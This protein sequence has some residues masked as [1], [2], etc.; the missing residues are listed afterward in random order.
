MDRVHVIAATGRTGNAL[1]RALLA[2]GVQV[3]P[4]VRD[5]AKFAALGLPASARVADLDDA[6]ALTTALRDATLIASTA[7]ARHAGAIIAAAPPAARLVMLGS[8]RRYSRWPDAH[9]SGVLAG[10]AALLN[11]G[12][13]GIMLHPT[14]IYGA[15]GENNVQRLARLLRRLPV[16]PLPGGGRNLVQPMHQDDVTACILAALDVPWTGPRSMVIAGPAP[17]TYADFIR[18]I[19]R[20]AGLAEPR[21]MPVPAGLLMALTPLT[22]LP[23]LPRVRTG[24]IRR[25]LED[26][27]FSVAEMKE[28]LGVMPVAFADGLARGFA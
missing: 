11:S 22:M 2:R 26:K 5:P 20:A 12:R 18:A 10:E 8:T 1:S 4:V 13:S 25:L 6:A 24:E 16:V 9:G 27:A 3:V 23:F 17:I 7:H 19:A 15:Q 14:M 28:A 21:I